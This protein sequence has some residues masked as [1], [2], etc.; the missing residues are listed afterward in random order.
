MH[1]AVLYLCVLWLV[2]GPGCEGQQ[3]VAAGGSG[4]IGADDYIR[5]EGPPPKFVF[6]EALRS[7]EPE[8]SRFI[9]EFV[10]V[11]LRGDYA[12]YR[13]RVSRQCEPVGRDTFERAWHAVK[14]VRV[15]SIRRLDG[16]VKYPP[17]VYLVRADVELREP[18]KKP[19]RE[20]AL[21]IFRE[22]GQWT[23]APAGRVLRRL[24][25]Q[26]QPTATQPG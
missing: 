23:T 3:D 26:S 6:P 19:L 21:L 2:V 24:R 25:A 8:L 10:Q 7:R 9:S 17:P 14:Q 20:V 13:L 12:G 5:T 4:Q 1:G 15:R 22:Q 16:A 18:A 11:C